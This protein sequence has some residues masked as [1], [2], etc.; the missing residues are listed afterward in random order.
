MKNRTNLAGHGFTILKSSPIHW[1]STRIEKSY[2]AA[3]TI[4]FVPISPFNL[5][6]FQT[7]RLLLQNTVIRGFFPV[8]RRC[9]SF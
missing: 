5:W 7:I 8:T 9:S 6:A 1:A 2:I 4:H 3:Y